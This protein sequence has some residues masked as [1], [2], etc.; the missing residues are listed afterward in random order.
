MTETTI[1]PAKKSAG[2]AP[3]REEVEA[4]P[5]LRPDDRLQDRISQIRETL[6]DH[7]DVV[8]K[9]YIPLD[10]IPEGWAYEWKRNSVIGQENPFYM[11]EM[12]RKGWEP[13]PSAR[14]PELMAYGYSGDYIERE[15][16]ILMERPAVFVKEARAK[17]SREARD[18][19]LAKERAMSAAPKGEFDRQVLS[20]SRTHG[21]AVLDVPN[22]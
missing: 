10:L 11:A 9:F 1:E 20:H 16:L 12:R 7:P 5:L 22:E 3:A 2:R 13:V 19:V 4:R 15:G 17:E 21:R 14:H 6:A 18:A 8:D